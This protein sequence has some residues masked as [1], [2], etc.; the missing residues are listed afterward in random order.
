MNG[1]STRSRARL[2]ERLGNCLAMNRYNTVFLRG[3]IG[4]IRRSLSRRQI[5][6]LS[7][8]DLTAVGAQ[9]D[10]LRQRHDRRWEMAILCSALL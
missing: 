4:V 2:R 8:L 3:M 10:P 9:D 6:S 1:L 7:L 5:D